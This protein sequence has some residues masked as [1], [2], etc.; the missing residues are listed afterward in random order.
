MA[1]DPVTVPS[2]RKVPESLQEKDSQ[3]DLCSPQ[4]QTCLAPG[5]LIERQEMT[6]LPQGRVSSGRKLFPSH[7]VR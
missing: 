3:W 5:Y 6:S 2:P 1:T 4:S 7:L